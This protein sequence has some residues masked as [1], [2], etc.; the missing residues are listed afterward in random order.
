[1]TQSLRNRRQWKQSQQGA[2]LFL[3][4]AGI[5]V[6]L[7]MAALAIDLSTLYL[8]HSEA[9]RAADA[10]ALGAAKAFIV[11][12]VT[13]DAGDP[14]AQSIAI[15]LGQQ[16]AAAALLQNNIAGHPGQL[17]GPLSSNPT[18]DFTIPAD[19]RVTVVVEQTGLPTF[20]SRIW[21]RVPNSV[22]ATA[23]AEAYNPSGTSAAPPIS[24]Q[25]VKP[26]IVPNRDPGQ[27]LAPP[28]GGPYDTF[29]VPATGM[30]SHPQRV[31][32]IPSGVVGE[33]I[34]FV[35][36]CPTLATCASGHRQNPPNA[37]Q[38]GSG[39]TRVLNLEFVAATLPASGAGGSCPSCGASL[40]TQFET[41]IACCN[42]A[43]MACSTGTGNPVLA[44]LIT[45]PSKSPNP[46][47]S[48]LQCVSHA[49]GSG[50]TQGQDS[51]DPLSFPTVS[52][53]PFRFVAGSNNPLTKSPSPTVAVGDV[54]STTDSLITI[55]IY[56]D[57]GGNI[58][59]PVAILGYMQVFVTQEN[60]DGTFDGV[61][62]NISG[63]GNTAGTGT[64][65][66]GGGV[67]PIPVRL[68]HN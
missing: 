37:R 14:T 18:F 22:T 43:A 41:D 31:V 34:H 62:L 2:T 20:F 15:T 33:T 53:A 66:S 3:A 16:N 45:D 25:C 21:S 7:V 63:C 59:N 48:G 6:A 23:I 55:L 11:S 8:A 40:A 26:F 30:V 32:A 68:I 38:T 19:P 42:T 60:G 13:T 4:L 5:V 44:D 49:L 56:D 47:S 27:P 28:P 50:P 36:D 57:S 39:P 1:M 17:F 52:G 46:L 61:V 9:L 29:V 54:V 35:A 58:S 67:S 24:A 51:L 10:A 64:A 65:I 12:G